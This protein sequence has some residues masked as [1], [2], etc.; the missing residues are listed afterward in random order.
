MI[1]SNNLQS[2]QSQ[3]IIMHIFHTLKKFQG[4]RD[5]TYCAI[6]VQT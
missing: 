1:S 6:N 3:W 2:L 5:E 4:E